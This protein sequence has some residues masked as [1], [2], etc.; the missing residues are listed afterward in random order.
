MAVARDFVN[1]KHLQAIFAELREEYL[2]ELIQADVGGLTAQAA[3]GR[4][5]ALEDIRNKLQSYINDELIRIRKGIS[6]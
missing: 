2:Q 4:I 3:H 6:S 1:N 5:K